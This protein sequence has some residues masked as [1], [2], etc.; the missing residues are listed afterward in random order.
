MTAVEGMIF[1]PLAILKS[2]HR[3]FRSFQE[4]TAFT[5]NHQQQGIDYEAIHQPAGVEEK[6][7]GE[8]QQE[9]VE[10]KEAIEQKEG[11]PHD[12]VADEPEADSS[13]HGDDANQH[14]LALNHELKCTQFAAYLL[15][16]SLMDRMVT[17]G[18]AFNEFVAI[19]QEIGWIALGSYGQELNQRYFNESALRVVIIEDHAQ[20]IGSQREVVQ[21]DKLWL[22]ECDRILNHDVFVQHF[23]E[24]HDF[25]E[26]L[27]IAP[28][29]AVPKEEDESKEV[30]DLLTDNEMDIASDLN[31]IDG[32]FLFKDEAVKEE[33]IKTEKKLLS[34]DAVKEEV[35]EVGLNEND[36]ID[37]EIAI[38][39]FVEEEAV[40]DSQQKPSVDEEEGF[41]DWENQEKMK[42][43]DQQDHLDFMDDDHFRDP[44]DYDGGDDGDD[45]MDDDE[46][47][48]VD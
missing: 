23:A 24:T 26:N 47:E 14:I 27:A 37:I 4:P 25:F 15:V 18:I 6:K 34:N 21:L 43:E 11:A 12:E 7:D 22:N 36:T 5:D 32:D 42:R 39:S 29:G 17:T 1:T 19:K 33:A 31:P 8:E 44:E 10:E 2:G 38:K 20:G 13:Q 40:K 35:K 30:I 45:E 16:K 46:M 28:R 41:M 48:D 9:G 3:I